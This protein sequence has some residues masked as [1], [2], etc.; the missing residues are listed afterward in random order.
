[1]IL[2][3]RPSQRAS[4]IFPISPALALSVSVLYSSFVSVTSDM[5]TLFLAN[6]NVIFTVSS[7]FPMTP[8]SRAPV[9]CSF[10]RSAFTRCECSA[11]LPDSCGITVYISPWFLVYPPL[12]IAGIYNH[13]IRNRRDFSAR[14]SGLDPMSVIR[15]PH[16][17]EAL[18]TQLF[19]H[20]AFPTK[21]VTSA[22]FRAM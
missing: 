2:G 11:P 22:K 9:L 5:P 16:P 3:P 6:K 13:D 15:A 21:A 14:V 19:K 8:C 7:H 12:Y 4:G 20:D 10:L 17:C 1:M 18:A